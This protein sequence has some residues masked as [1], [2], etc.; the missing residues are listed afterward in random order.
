MSKLPMHFVFVCEM[1]QTKKLRLHTGIRFLFNTFRYFDMI[2]R[3]PQG[4]FC[5]GASAASAAE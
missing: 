5:H 2:V 4:S 1:T 3:L